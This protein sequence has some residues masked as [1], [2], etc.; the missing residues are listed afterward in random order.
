MEAYF[1]VQLYEEK[2]FCLNCWKDYFRIQAMWICQTLKEKTT[3]T[4]RK[5]LKPNLWAVMTWSW[6]TAKYQ[7]QPSVFLCNFQ[8]KN[9]QQTSATKS[10]VSGTRSPQK[11]PARPNGK[12]AFSPEA[13]SSAAEPPSKRS[14]RSR[15]VTCDDAS[16]HGG[17]DEGPMQDDEEEDSS[18]V[19]VSFTTGIVWIHRSVSD[20]RERDRDRQLWES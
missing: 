12:R 7:P 15:G 16:S 18:Q 2:R 1:L 8:G 20:P 17:D 11:S 5:D 10:R 14:N 4:R 3:S 13:E 6:E 9:Q 19:R